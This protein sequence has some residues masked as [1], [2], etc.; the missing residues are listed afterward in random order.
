[1][2]SRF[3][4]AYIVVSIYPHIV[5]YENFFGKFS[6][7]KQDL[8]DAT[9]QESLAAIKELYLSQPYA[10]QLES[11]LSD[12]KDK[13]DAMLLDKKIDQILH[14]LMEE[15]KY[16]AF[17]PMPLVAFMFALE[18]EVTNIRLILVG[19][20]NQIDEEAIRERMRPIYGS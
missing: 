20:D 14:G 8:I 13:I 6:I 9:D 1:M 4:T 3:F 7:S 5:L 10:D 12:S 16:Q 11:I 2:L 19:K 18:R 17:G 15:G